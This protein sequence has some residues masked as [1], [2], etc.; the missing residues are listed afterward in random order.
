[1]R[2]WLGLALTLSAL[3]AVVPGIRA[4][5]ESAPSITV[6]GTATVAGRP[7]T[8]DV[9]AGVVTQAAT[10][11]QALADNGVAMEK[12][13]KVIAD[14]GIAPRDVQTTGISVAPQRAQPRPGSMQPPNIVGYEVS[15]QVH[16]KVRDLAALGRLL[17][18]IV[19][20][21][22]NT[23]GGISFSI[24]DPTPLLQQ[25]RARAVADALAKAQVY[26]T[27][28]GVKLGRVMAIRDATTPGMPRPVAA[29][30]LATAAVPVAVGEQELEASVSVTYAIE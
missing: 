14:L 17:D 21:G 13:L 15:N 24:A 5:E 25:A 22:A 4:A 2:M 23:L 8:A 29:R 27:A 30:M 12:V 18:A 1:M 9:T 6:V 20:Q 26:A 19:G 7:D 28:A 3:V 11:A 16:V 10:A